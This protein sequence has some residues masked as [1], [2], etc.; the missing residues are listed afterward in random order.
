MVELTI[1]NVKKADQIAKKLGTTPTLEAAA[2]AYNVQVG[3][4]GTDSTLTMNAQIINGIGNE[5]K[6][7]GAAFNKAFQSK[8]SEPIT[9]NNGVYVMKVNSIAKK[10]AD[11]PELLR[12][13]QNNVQE[14]YYNSCQDGLRV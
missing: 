5:P 6:L 4:A 2:A 10:T 14:V 3:T 13:R 1:R 9:G 8:P 11:S 12:Y 7:I